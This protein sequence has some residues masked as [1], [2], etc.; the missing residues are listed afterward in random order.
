MCG[1]NLGSSLLT[2]SYLPYHQP[3]EEGPACMSMG[4]LKA[5]ALAQVSLALSLDPQLHVSS[6]S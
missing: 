2:L 5:S 4:A 1:K 3:W 6:V